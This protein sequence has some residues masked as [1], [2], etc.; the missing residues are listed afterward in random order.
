MDAGDVVYQVQAERID[1]AFA[2]IGDFRFPLMA[3]VIPEAVGLCLEAP[4]KW[5]VS[6]GQGA[7]ELTV[8][9]LW[10]NKDGIG[11]VQVLVQKAVI[12]KLPYE[13]AGESSSQK[14]SIHPPVWPGGRFGKTD[15]G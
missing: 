2:D 6:K 3:E 10:I 12:L 8:I 14:V 5:P 15:G 11:M 9:P 4:V 1:G 13:P 7:T